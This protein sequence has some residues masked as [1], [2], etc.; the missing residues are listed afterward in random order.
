TVLGRRRTGRVVVVGRAR[1]AGFAW[2][3]VCV[4]PHPP[5]APPSEKEG[6]DPTPLPFREGLGE[7]QT[8]GG[9]KPQA[10][11]PRGGRGAGAQRRFRVAPCLRHAAS[12][13]SPSFREGGGRSNSPPLQ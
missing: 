12:S 6:G 2:R 10:N 4:T 7:G 11:R 8:A 9:P 5:P 3:R 13:P 1:N